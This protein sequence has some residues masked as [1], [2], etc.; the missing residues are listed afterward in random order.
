MNLQTTSF[1][2]FHDTIS[3]LFHPAVEALFPEAKDKSH[4]LSVL[5]CSLEQSSIHPLPLPLYHRL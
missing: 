2:Q 5:I 4:L 3:G 1:Y